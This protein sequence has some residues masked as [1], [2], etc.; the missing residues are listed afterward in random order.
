MLK[1]PEGDFNFANFREMCSLVFKDDDIRK[2]EWRI[3]EI[4]DLFDLDKDGVLKEEE[5]TR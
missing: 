2:D 5:L 1:D 3:R 4:F